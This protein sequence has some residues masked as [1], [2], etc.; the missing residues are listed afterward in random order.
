MTAN[1]AVSVI[2]NCYNHQDYVG[3]A[4]ESVLA[5]THRD[6]ELIIID[7]GSTDGTRKV[8][9]RFTD[10][11]IRPFLHDDNTTVSRR[12]N[13]GV[14]AARGE[15]VTILYSDDWFLPRKLEHQLAVFAS[16]PAEYGVVYG[17]AIG[18]NQLTGVRWQRPS[19]AHSGPMMPAMFDRFFDGSIDM[20]TPLT[21]RACFLQYPF[22]DELFS[23]GEYVFFRIAMGWS[24]QFDP[25][26]F[27]V[28]RDHGDNMSKA[29]HRNHDM[30][31]AMLDRMATEPDFREEWRPNLRHLRALAYRNH[32]WMAL[33]MNHSDNRWVWRQFRHSLAAEP[34]QIVQPKML[35][36]LALGALPNRVRVALN[37]IVNDRRPRPEN[38]NIKETQ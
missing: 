4:I 13:E 29:T 9:E 14:A 26:P 32:T 36:A 28:L 10:A 7:N 23:D 37:R 21:R 25:E 6:F 20:S 1:P 16:L 24:F 35:A 18:F 34:S 12:L 22:Y 17:P 2:L 30:M 27:V 8:I 19:L 38:T 15:F 31:M 11:R 3:E 5:Q 33:R